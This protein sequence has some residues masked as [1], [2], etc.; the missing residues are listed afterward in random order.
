MTYFFVLELI[1]V[2]WIKLLFGGIVFGV[3]F[4]FLSIFFRIVNDDDLNNLRDMVGGLGSLGGVLVM[5][6]NFY[7]KVK[8]L[9][10][11]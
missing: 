5:I 8:N 11:F 10:R 3:L 7:E 9:F 4:L 2:S 6:I 1:F